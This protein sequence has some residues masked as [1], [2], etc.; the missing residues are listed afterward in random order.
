MSQTLM[1]QASSFGLGTLAQQLIDKFGSMLGQLLIEWLIKKSQQSAVAIPAVF[2]IKAIL[3]SLI[4]NY[5]PALIDE[6][7]T[8][9]KSQS[10]FAF[11]LAAT[12]LEASKQNIL[13]FL[14]NFLDTPEAQAA[15]IKA[16]NTP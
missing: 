5:G 8:Y 2:D 1:A 4:T 6:A 7:V 11:T 16:S 3:T 14:I 10:G 12:L 9:L 13:D 15:I